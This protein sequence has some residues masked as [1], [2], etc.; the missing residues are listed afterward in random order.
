MNKEGK[1]FVNCSSY[2]KYIKWSGNDR[3][4]YM[5]VVEFELSKYSKNTINGLIQ[6]LKSR[7]FIDDYIR[8]KLDDHIKSFDLLDVQLSNG[9]LVKV[10]K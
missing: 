1:D 10:E 7:K 8:A 6:D 5:F 3:F 2:E 9:K 4:S